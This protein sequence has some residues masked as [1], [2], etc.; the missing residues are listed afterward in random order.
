MYIY[1]YVYNII[2][3]CYLVAAGI[4]FNKSVYIVNET[5]SLVQPELV[6]TIPS[7]TD[8]TIQVTVGKGL[9]DDNGG[10]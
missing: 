7:S 1:N 5:D 8:I 10:I 9:D 3:I 6:L 2:R 4:F